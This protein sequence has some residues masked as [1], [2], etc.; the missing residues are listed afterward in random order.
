MCLCHIE[1][2]KANLNTSA[3]F[4][5]ILFYLLTFQVLPLWHFLI[6]RQLN[7]L[8]WIFRLILFIGIKMRGFSKLVMILLQLTNLCTS[9]LECP[10]RCFRSHICSMIFEMNAVARLNIKM[11]VACIYMPSIQIDSETVLSYMFLLVRWH[12]YIGSAT[13]WWQIY[14]YRMSCSSLFA[15]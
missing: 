9:C 5:S 8:D 12:V 14:I 3:L 15:K 6:N 7:I 10:S 13:R 11:F 4:S 2:K 1:D